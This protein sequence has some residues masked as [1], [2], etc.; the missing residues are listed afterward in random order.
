MPRIFQQAETCVVKPNP[1]VIVD[2]FLQS[3]REGQT[4]AAVELFS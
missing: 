2:S 3:I 1:E 4:S